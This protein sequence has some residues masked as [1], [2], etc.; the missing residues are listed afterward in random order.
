MDVTWIVRGTDHIANTSKQVAILSA[1]MQVSETRPMPKFSHV[2]LIFKDGKKM[3]KRDGAASLLDYRDS[4][5]DPDAMFNFLLRT[6]WGPKVDDKTTAT[7]D[8]ERAIELFLDGGSMKASHA[9]FDAMKL[10]SF[11]R[12]YKART[13]RAAREQPKP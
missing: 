5:V 6:G 10:A 1:L 2:G 4:G 8:R 7:I 9:N 3:S 13:E 12:K 11:D